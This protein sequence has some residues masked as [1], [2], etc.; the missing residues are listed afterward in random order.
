MQKAEQLMLATMWVFYIVTSLF[1]FVLEIYQR[2]RPDSHSY[3][4][5]NISQAQFKY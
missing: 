3:I 5:K 4:Y 2:F 1:L